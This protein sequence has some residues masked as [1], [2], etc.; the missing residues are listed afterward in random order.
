MVG[1]L[2]K[3]NTL[4]TP[5]TFHWCWLGR[6]GHELDAGQRRWQR[7]WKRRFLTFELAH[8]SIMVAAVILRPPCPPPSIDAYNNQQTNYA[9]TH[10]GCRL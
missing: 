9:V 6:E 5:P 8:R 3:V 4:A 1:T 7:R 2:I 10:D